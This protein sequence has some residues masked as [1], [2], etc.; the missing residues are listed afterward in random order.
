VRKA[1]ALR[2]DTQAIIAHLRRGLAQ[3]GVRHRAVH[4][5]GVQTSVAPYRTTGNRRARCSTRPAADPDGAGP[6]RASS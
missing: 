6:R 2:V 4:V 1:I 5:M 3:A